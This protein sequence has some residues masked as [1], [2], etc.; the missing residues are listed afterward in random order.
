MKLFIRFAA[1]YFIAIGLISLAAPQAGSGQ[2]GQTLSAF[3]I[4]VAR[5]LG[6]AIMTVGLINWSLSSRQSHSTTGLLWANLFMNASLATIDVYAVLQ[7]TIGAS[8]WFG[9]SM[10]ALLIIGCV[11]FLYQ[12]Y[13]KNRKD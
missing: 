4:F 6:A 12:T 10:H 2:M 5:S 1:V 7:K 11:Y 13:P 3:D 9:I 8:S